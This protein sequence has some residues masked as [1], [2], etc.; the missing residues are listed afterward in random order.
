MDRSRYPAGRNPERD[1]SC[2]FC[3][4]CGKRDLAATLQQSLLIVAGIATVGVVGGIA[5][6]LVDV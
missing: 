3:A 5:H 1:R 6:S 4:A 2:S